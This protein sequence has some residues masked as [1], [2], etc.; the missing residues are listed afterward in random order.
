[1]LSTGSAPSCADGGGKLGVHPFAYA[2]KLYMERRFDWWGHTYREEE[3]KYRYL[4]Q[5]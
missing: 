2:A 4:A 3:R 5:V 1:M